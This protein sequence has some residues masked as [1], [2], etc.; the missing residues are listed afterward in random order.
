MYFQCLKHTYCNYTFELC[1]AN[2][3]RLLRTSNKSGFPCL[4]LSASV[5]PESSDLST[6]SNPL[7]CLHM[8][9]L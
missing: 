1:V 3:L 8:M 5:F 7:V 4:S 9:I 2:K 6:A